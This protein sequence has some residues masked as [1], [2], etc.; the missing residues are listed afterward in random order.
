M[1]RG[2][3]HM[4]VG[5]SIN[6]VYN[7][8]FQ[9]SLQSSGIQFYFDLLKNKQIKTVIHL[10]YQCTKLQNIIFAVIIHAFF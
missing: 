8:E 4:Y 2:I 7:S 6:L 3:T 9:T 5:N 10:P 1:G